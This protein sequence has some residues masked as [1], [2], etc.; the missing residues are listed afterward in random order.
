[1]TAYYEWVRE[2]FIRVLF[3]WLGFLAVVGAAVLI[4]TFVGVVL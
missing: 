3:A 2:A 4:E 1:M